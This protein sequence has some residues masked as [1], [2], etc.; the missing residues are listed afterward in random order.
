[1]NFQKIARIACL[2]LNISVLA[3]A[4]KISQDSSQ[5]TVPPQPGVLRNTLTAKQLTTGEKF[6]VRVVQQFGIR[7]FAGAALSSGISQWRNTPREW[8]QG[9]DAYGTRY[10]SAFGVTLSRQVFAFGLES[11]L[12]EDPRYFPSSEKG[13]FPRLKN[14]V[15]QSLIAKSDDGNARFAYAR[16]I[17]A[18]SAGQLANSW[19][20]RSNNSVG[21]GLERGALTL[22]GD[23]GFFF[24][25]EFAPFTR[26]TPFRRH[27]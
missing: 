19:Q 26:N 17:S 1:M 23:A 13:F 10:G 14:I 20:P 24:L 9:A 11:T 15:K 5:P 4:Q 18:F 27:P 12:H 16:V 2:T 8:G 21:D 25:Q 3:V 6:G 22:A 7:G